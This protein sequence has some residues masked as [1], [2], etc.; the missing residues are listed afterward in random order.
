MIA[1]ATDGREEPGAFLD[2][3][4]AGEEGGAARM[5]IANHLFQR[6]PVTLAALALG[7]AKRLPVSL[8]AMSPFSVHPVQAAMAAATLDEAFPGR[9]TLCFGVGAP[10][11]LAAAGLDASKPLGPMREALELARALLAGDAVRY[12]GRIFRVRDRAL[13]TGERK[14]PIL[15]AASGPKMLALAGAAAD[16]V[17]ISAGTSV[18]FVRWSLAHAARG[19]AGRHLRACGLVYA[20][21]DADREAAHARLRRMLAVVLRG[22][23]HALNLELA[24]TSLDQAALRESA[25]R[26]DWAGAEALISPAVLA[27]HAICGTPDEVR[28]RVAAYRAAGIGEIVL[29]GARDGA[30]AAALLDACN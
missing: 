5:W 15:L 7:A 25:A 26:G 10:A 11:D 20:A 23:H 2:K 21:V 19:A 12:D 30:Q 27:R 4:R 17:L 9:V 8:M 22:A 13:A 1:L 16:G 18:E 14:V 29:S 6:D 24:G 3:V 28:A